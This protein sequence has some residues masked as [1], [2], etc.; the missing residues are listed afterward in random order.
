MGKHGFVH[1]EISANDLTATAAFYQQ[2]FNWTVQ[3]VPEMNY[4]LFETGE[5]P[6]G[7]FSPV[8][9]ENPAGTVMIYIATDNIE[10]TLAAVEKAGGVTVLPRTEIPST[11]WFAQFKDPTGNLLGIFQ[12]LP[13]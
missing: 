13:E 10:D 11:G 1:V 5:G 2:V 3:P 8:M 9:A 12:N 6:G 7:G 4:A